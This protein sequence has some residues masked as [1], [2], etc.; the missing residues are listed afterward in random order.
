MPGFL[1][2]KTAVDFGFFVL[3]PV[4]FCW[5]GSFV[6]HVRSVVFGVFVAHGLGRL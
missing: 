3:F 2:E 6:A 5:L 4:W 1:R